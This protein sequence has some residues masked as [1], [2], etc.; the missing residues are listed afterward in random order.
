MTEDLDRGAWAP[1]PADSV[2]RIIDEQLRVMEKQL[3]LMKVLAATAAH[4]GDTTTPDSSQSTEPYP[5]RVPLTDVQRD[6][7]ITCQ[8]S[9][10][11]SAA[12]NLMTLLHLRG[13]LD[14]GVLQESLRRLAIRHESLRTTFDPSG[15]YQLV[16]RTAEMEL[17][18]DDLS[19]RPETERASRFEALLDV[20]KSTP[21]DLINGPLFRPRLV[22][23]GD[24]DQT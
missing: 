8:L 4:P 1:I 7:W 15:D 16:G 12:Y 22:R 24:E 23:L 9:G 5:M 18:F 13:D 11:G 2:R 6:V 3:G 10:E 21:Y 14:V 20:E 17:P 19:D